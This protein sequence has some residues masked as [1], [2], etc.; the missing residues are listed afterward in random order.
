MRIYIFVL[1]TLTVLCVVWS[2][3]IDSVSWM[4]LYDS[5]F[6]AFHKTLSADQ[7]VSVCRTVT[8]ILR[9]VSIP[10]VALNIL[11]LVAGIL[12]LRW[13]SKPKSAPPTLDSQGDKG[14][15]LILTVAVA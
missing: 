15:S 7:V 3:L 14:P 5:N 8:A 12:S 11:W 1:I 6:D 4:W 9:S 13:I 2:L 10:S